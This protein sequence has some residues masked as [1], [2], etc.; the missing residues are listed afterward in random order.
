MKIAGKD[1]SFDTLLK[2]VGIEKLLLLAVCGVVIII[3][4]FDGGTKENEQPKIKEYSSESEINYMDEMELKLKNILE[5]AKGLSN[6]SVMIRLI[7]SCFNLCSVI[8][9]FTLIYIYAFS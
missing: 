7:I 4:S 8:A 2:N 5:G 6:I 1:I 9:I 3:C